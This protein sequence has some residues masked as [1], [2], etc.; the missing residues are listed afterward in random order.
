MNNFFINKIRNLRMNL[1]NSNLN[2]VDLVRSLMY[3]RTCN[4]NIR[5]VHPDEISKIIGRMKSSKSC[6]VDTIDSYIIKL[7]KNE[8]T[9]VI[10]HLVN[11]SIMNKIFPKNWKLAKKIISFFILVTMAL[12]ACTTQVQLCSKCLTLG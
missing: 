3:R 10:T 8:L 4:F 5:P 12:E 6:G 9:P 7:A 11:L 2:P 1:P